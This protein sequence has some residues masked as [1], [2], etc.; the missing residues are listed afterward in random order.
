LIGVLWLL[1]GLRILSFAHSWPLFLIAVGV[2][3]FFKRTM[4]GYGYGFPPQPPA[5]APP[6]AAVTTTEIV[7][8]DSLHDH[9]GNGEEGR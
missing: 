1:Q 8:S 9:S 4:Y 5:A 2:M 6:A 3:L 7:P